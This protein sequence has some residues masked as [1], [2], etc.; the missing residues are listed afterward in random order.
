MLLDH[1][2][3]EIRSLEH[4]DKRVKA[5]N[6]EFVKVTH[7]LKTIP[8]EVWELRTTYRAL[9]CAGKH[10]VKT[11]RGLLHV[12]ELVDGDW[13]DTEDGYEGIVEC[14]PTGELREFYDL[15]VDSEDHLYYT[16][17]IV[18]HNSTGICGAEYFKLNF[19]PYYSSLLLAPLQDHISTL[20]DKMMEM[21]RGSVC[22]PEYIMRHK[23]RSNK[24]YKDSPNG[25]FVKFLHVLTDPTKVRGNSCPAVVI[26]ES[27]DFDPEHLP[28]IEQVQ[29]NYPKE[30]TTIFTGTSKDLDTCLEGQYNQGSR[31]VWMVPCTCKD[32]WHPMNEA[33]LVPKMVQVDGLSCPNNKT[34]LLD[35]ATGMFVHEDENLLAQHRV[36][37]HAPQVIVPE[38]AYGEGWVQIFKDFKRYPL[39]KFLME[40]WGIAVDAGVSELKESDLK[41]CCCEFTFK[42]LQERYFSGKDRYIRLISGLD[43][44]GSDWEPAHQLKKSYTVHVIYG[45]RGDGKMVL[46]Y[47]YRYAGANYQDIAGTIVE[48]HNR[49]KTFAMG[50]DNGG[51]QY[52]NA[53]MRDC[54]RIG[55]NRIM[56]FQYTDTKLVLD[57]IPNPD[58][59][60]LSLHRSDS[61]S[62]LIGD[63]K[64]E[65]IIFPR[66]DEAQPFV[67]DCLNVRRNITES[68]SGKKVMRYIRHGSKADDFFH[69]TNYAAMIKRIIGDEPM[70]PNKQVMAEVASLL[71]LSTGTINGFDPGVYG[72]SG[73]H[74]SG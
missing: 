67:G 36:S 29:K 60:I 46:L 35:P 55:T 59:N 49:F 39:N 65:R 74:I 10:L 31:G 57:H 1:E 30:R 68:A 34:K 8:M 44:G 53:Y 27:Q 7:A 38:Y 4:L 5:P 3:A 32:R 33:E 17:G 11:A 2:I 48:A 62:A 22:P 54:G 14:R 40:V 64:D 45:V 43:W 51:G 12:Q 72:G 47:A 52:Y 21:Q 42:Q 70:I 56:H 66:W 13:I 18:S 50:T 16:N 28:E 71:G 24:Y 25:G 61:L 6:G 41:K 73:G 37:F 69:A 19:L 15:R 9:D 26:D 20:A 58:A 23:L 63:I